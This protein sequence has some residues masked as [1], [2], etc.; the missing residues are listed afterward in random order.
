VRQLGFACKLGNPSILNVTRIELAYRT[1]SEE[2]KETLRFALE[3]ARRRQTTLHV[4]RAFWEWEPIP[5]TAELEHDRGAQE[6]EAWLAALVREVVGKVADVEI[7]QSTVEDGPAPTLL[8]AAQHAELLIVG[9][10]G[11]GGFA[12]LLLGSVSQ[13]CAHHASCRS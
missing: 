9:S 5:G 10:R 4:V 3:E 7:E 1:G 6:R 13:Q 12:G 11:H 2:S 8:A